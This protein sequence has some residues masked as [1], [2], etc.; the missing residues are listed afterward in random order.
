MRVIRTV[1][2]VVLLNTSI[3]AW[4]ESLV[5]WSNQSNID[6]ARSGKKIS[7]TDNIYQVPAA[8]IADFVS[9]KND[10]SRFIVATYQ[11]FRSPSECFN[12]LQSTLVPATRDLVGSETFSGYKEKGNDEKRLIIKKVPNGTSFALMCGDQSMK[13]RHLGKYA[14]QVISEYKQSGHDFW[15]GS[16]IRL[17]K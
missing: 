2:C 8:D 15:G 12:Y 7:N 17:S 11:S 13:L 6:I 10:R 9:V 1:L 4:A 5:Y 14:D 3:P 16:L